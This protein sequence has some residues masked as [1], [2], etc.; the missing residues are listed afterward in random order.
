MSKYVLDNESDLEFLDFFFLILKCV[1]LV[2]GNV[3]EFQFLGN[4][5][6]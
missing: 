6:F 1:I 3:A 5:V 4:K 2:I